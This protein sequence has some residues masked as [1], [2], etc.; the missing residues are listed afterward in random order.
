MLTFEVKYEKHVDVFFVIM[1][2]FVDLIDVL[3]DVFIDY[4]NVDKMELLFKIRLIE[5]KCSYG[6]C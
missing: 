6:N 3:N 5:I 1:F 2:L 4:I